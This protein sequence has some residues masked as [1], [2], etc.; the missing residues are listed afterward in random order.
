M[1]IVHVCAELVFLI[2]MAETA[3]FVKRKVLLEV[4][5]IVG[6]LAMAEYGCQ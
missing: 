4:L 1:N 6:F 3:K 5:A 2:A